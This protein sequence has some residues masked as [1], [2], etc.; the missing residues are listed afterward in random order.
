MTL[1]SV[2]G[3][4]GS[5][6]LS[7]S[8]SVISVA[9][10]AGCPGT[11]SQAAVA[12]TLRPLVVP[13][14]NEARDEALLETGERIYR[15]LAEGEPNRLLVDDAGLRRLVSDDAA[16]RYAAVRMGISVRLAV[17]PAEFEAFRNSRYTGVC[18]QH[19]RVEPAGTGVGLLER[20]W[21]FDRALVVGQQPGGRRFASWV[22][23]TF[24]YTPEGFLAIDIAR[25]ETPRWEHADL[26]LAT[27][28]MEV[29]V[30]DPRPVVGVTG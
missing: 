17:D 12:P 23:G 5:R 9:A 22:E 18:L 19:A 2:T 8:L 1:V 4:A 13:A 7:I 6:C 11:T 20:G 3:C 27:C 24:V 21:M 25:I 10:L 14:S 30:H 26:E 16:T 29:G 15:A 28:D